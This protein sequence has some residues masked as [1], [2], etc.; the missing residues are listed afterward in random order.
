[1]NRP[2]GT[3]DIYGQDQIVKKHIEEIVKTIALLNNFEEIETPIFES[4]NVFKKSVGETSD[5]VSKEMYLFNDKKGREMVLRPEGTAGAIRAIVEN[6]LFSKQLP[7]KLFYYGPMF[8]YERP[9]KGRQRQFT[10]FGIEMI[11]NK[12][13]YI[14]AEVILFASSILESLNIKNKL[15]IN[16]LGDSVTRKNYSKALKKYFS[17]YKS[18]LSDDSVKRIEKNP[19][20]IL[21]DKID[22]KKSFVI[23]APKISEFY[24]KETNEYFLKLSSFLKKMGINFEIDHKL[25]R[26][27]DYY[28]DTS[29][30]F[31]STSGKAGSQSTL[32]G[33]GRY[34]NLISQFGGPEL[35]GIGF[36]IG[37]ERIMNELDYNEIIDSNKKVVEIFVINLS[38]ASLETSLGIVHMLR[39]AGYIVEWNG[40]TVKLQK[41]FATSDKFGSKINIII[42]EKE[43]KNGNVVIKD[44]VEQKLVKINEIIDYIDAKLGE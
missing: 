35:S 28:A 17:K 20:R 29:F 23:N 8:R 21:D 5:I 6:K 19:L 4:S 39:R 13:P 26:G 37:I 42:G 25:V 18:E 32:I 3:K 15:I 11:S 12:S 27:L 7:L 36:A 33:G 16:S 24:S 43:I 9:Q 1:M 14:D 10:Q 40:K 2:K 44:K 30:E 31:V 38:D 41:G 22:G 34:D